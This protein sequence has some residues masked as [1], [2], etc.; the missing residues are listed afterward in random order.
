MK[1]ITAKYVSINIACPLILA[2]DLRHKA[3]ILYPI[4]CIQNLKSLIFVIV[5]SF[6]PLST[7]Y[8]LHMPPFTLKEITCQID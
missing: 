4:K 2:V 3:L 1:I 5:T 8:L 7:A 6:C